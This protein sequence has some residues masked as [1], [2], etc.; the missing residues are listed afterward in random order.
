MRPWAGKS[1]PYEHSSSFSGATQKWP[2]KALTSTID[3]Q[4][5]CQKVRLETAKLYVD[6]AYLC[7]GLWLLQLSDDFDKLSK[8]EKT[9]AKNRAFSGHLGNWTEFPV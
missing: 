6:D 3:K 1:F 9:K 2:I 4:I 8:E 7:L 5:Q